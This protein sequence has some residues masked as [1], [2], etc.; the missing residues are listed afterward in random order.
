MA[1]SMTWNH[2]L[3]LTDVEAG[4]ETLVR[5]DVRT[6]DHRHEIRTRLDA[7]A[8]EID[9]RHARRARDSSG[10]AAS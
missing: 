5:D 1:S 6:I 2:A 8:Y 9:D 4:V 3:H 7:R 10:P